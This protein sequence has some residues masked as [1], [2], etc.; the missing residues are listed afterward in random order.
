MDAYGKKSSCYRTCQGSGPGNTTVRKLLSDQR[1][2]EL[3]EGKNSGRGEN[4]CHHMKITL[5]FTSFLPGLLL[6]FS[7]SFLGSFLF[8]LLSF[9][10]VFLSS[11]GRHFGHRV[12][13]WAGASIRPPFPSVTCT[14][15]A[16][17]PPPFVDRQRLLVPNRGFQSSPTAL[18]SPERRG[19]A[20]SAWG[21]PFQKCR[22]SHRSGVPGSIGLYG[23]SPVVRFVGCWAAG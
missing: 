22:C 13:F 5:T 6:S 20:A 23:L 8:I 3:S 11:D 19:M 10:S 18:S 4:G 1:C 17:Y 9:P 2:F 14:S 12:A 21:M 15:P 16:V 7:G